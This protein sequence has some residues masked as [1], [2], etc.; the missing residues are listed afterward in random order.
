VAGK[1]RTPRAREPLPPPL[2]PETRTVGQVV[3]ESVRF[4][5]HNFWRTV[6]LGLPVAL[7]TQLSIELSRGSRLKSYEAFRDLREHGMTPQEAARLAAALVDAGARDDVGFTLLGRGGIVWTVV[8]GALLLTASFVLASKVVSGA[9]L[10]WRTALVAYGVGVLVFA[11]VPILTLFLVLPAIAWLAFI[12]LCVPVAVIERRGFV[13]SLQRATRLARA[14]YVHALG[15]LAALTIV[16]VVTRLA[17]LILLR[18]AGEATART[19]AFL[20]DIVISPL[21]FVGAVLVYFDQTARL[22]SGRWQERSRDAD[23]S[24]AVD[25]DR[26]GPANAAVEPGPAARGEPGRRGARR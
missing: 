6:V 22:S 10:D 18:S 26:P 12:G 15:S 13:A 9:R 11:P 2:P 4:Y 25:A 17:L 21:L 20:A 19:A 1:P 14:D 7:L 23:L 3:A 8:L 24:D 16:Y 5:R